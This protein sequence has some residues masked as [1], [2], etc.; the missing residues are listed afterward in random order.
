MDETNSGLCSKKKWEIYV[1]S[2][3]SIIMVLVS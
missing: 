3:D 2:L 1:E